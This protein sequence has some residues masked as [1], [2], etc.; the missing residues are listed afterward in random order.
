MPNIVNHELL[1]AALVG[2]QQQLD[3]I[4]ARMAEIRSALGRPGCE[5]WPESSD[6]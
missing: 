6:L 1:A 3:G 4:H 2:Y 5:S